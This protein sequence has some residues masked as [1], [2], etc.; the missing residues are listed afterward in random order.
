MAAK[1]SNQQAPPPLPRAVWLLSW[2]SFFAD[3]S[4]EMIYPL[5]PLFIVGV[6]GGTKT[7]LG[8]IEGSAVMLISLMAAVAG[9]RSDAARKRVPWIRWGYGLPVLGKGLMALA[10][11]WPTVM[12][13]RLLDRFGKGLRG[14]PRDA[15]IVDAVTALHRGRAFGLHRAFDTTGALLGVLISA[16]LLWWLTGSP[17]G[18]GRGH[19][20]SGDAI[21][22]IFGIGAALGLTALALTF[23]IAEAAPAPT[24]ASDVSAPSPRQAAHWR[25]LPLT[26]WRAVGVLAL[27]SLANSSDTFL[28]LRAH[29]LGCQPWEVVLLYAL[30]NL[31]YAALSYPVG[32]WSD[33]VG[34]WRVISLGWALYTAVY[35]A[36]ALLTERDLLTLGVLM[37]M[38]G[39]YM[40]LTEGV[41]KALIADCAPANQ[42]GA[43]IGIFYCVNGITSLCASLLVGALWDAFGAR[44]AFLTE[45]SCAIAALIALR[46]EIARAPIRSNRQ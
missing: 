21:R 17:S 43:A 23:C 9:R 20:V 6:L 15:L 24:S 31:S 2:V 38:Y 41:G 32:A 16:V 12:A 8:L 1:E 28:L 4:G 45:A 29:E 13:G 35:L 7:E 34:R 10:T 36:F 25:D 33:G 39:A 5:I 42:R 46:I 40:A 14:A 44:L 3:I 30:F 19:L 22:I 37:T 27:F 26:Y 11:G 18:E